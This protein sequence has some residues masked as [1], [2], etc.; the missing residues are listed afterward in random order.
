MDGDEQSPESLAQILQDEGLDPSSLRELLE[1]I[2]PVDLADLLDDLDIDDRVRVVEALD[3]STAAQVLSALSHDARVKIVDRMG[4]ARLKDVIEKMPADV[5][6]DVIDHLPVHRETSVMQ[7]LDK[8]HAKDIAELRKYDENTAGGRMTLNFVSVPETFT[9]AET[10]RAIQGAVTAETIEYVYVVDDEDRLR[11]VC[12]I[13]ALLRAAP[14]TPV[15][16]FMHRDVTFVGAHLDQE[17][18]ARIAQKYNLRAIPVV[19]GQMRLCGVVTMADIL[20]VVRQEANE[21]IMKMA[22]AEHVHPVHAPFLARL[23]A[24]LPWLGAAMTLELLIAWIMKGF[25]SDEI[26]MHIALMYFIPVIMAMGGSVGLQSATMVVRG[27]ATGELTVKRGFRVVGSEIRVGIVIGALA[28][29]A[30]GFMA[31][32]MASHIPVRLGLIVLASMTMSIT[33]AATVGAMTP[34]LLQRMNIDPAVASGPFITAL[35][36]VVNV[37]IYLTM[38]TVFILKM[39]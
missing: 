20:A 35:N 8:E 31:F 38:A 36:D 18:V 10:L 6:A 14:D 21:D 28:G 7:K 25:E 34:L 15:S 27:L 32:L 22:G 17:E 19:D 9:A 13:Y 26:R 2:Q 29:I 16:K 33:V 3:A 12:S 23:K 1:A 5:V 11:G 4:E 39:S 30:T 24:R 37:T